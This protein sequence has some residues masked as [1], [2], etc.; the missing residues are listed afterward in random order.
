MPSATLTSKGQTT[1]PREVRDFLK[2]KPGDKLEFKLNPD[3]QTV[4]LKAANIHISS[5]RGI[6]KRDGMKPYNPAER[7]VALLKRTLKK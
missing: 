1:I 3:G 2:L 7:K 4:L 5:L 6:L